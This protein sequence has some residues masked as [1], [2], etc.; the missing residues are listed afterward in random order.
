MKDD[1]TRKRADFHLVLHHEKPGQAA[2]AGKQM[3]ALPHTQ[4]G[5]P[6][7]VD[8]HAI[9]WRACHTNVRRLQCRIVKA[10]KAGRWGKVHALQR[11]L[12]GS[13]SGKALAVKRVSSNSGK[14]TP[15]V[16][17]QLWQ[18]PD[19]KAKAIADL[20]H[21]GYQP[22]PLRRVA[23]PKANGSQRWL[24]IPTLADRAMQALHLLALDPVAETLADP[25]SYGF[26]PCRSTADAMSQCYTALSHQSSAAWVLEGDIKACFD[27][28]SHDWLLAHIRTD[29]SVLRKWLKAGYLKEGRW[30]PTESGTPQGGIIS[31]VLANQTLDGLE[32]E[33]R[34]RFAP[35]RSV[36]SRNKVNLI[37]YADDFIITGS[38]EELLKNEVRPV[39]EKFLK[40]RG[41]ELSKTKT[42]ITHIA[43]GFDFLGQQVRKYGG[44]YL[45]RPST[46][47]PARLLANVRRTLKENPQARVGELIVRLNRIIKGWANYHRHAAS[48]QTFSQV[49]WQIGQMV[50]RWVR[51]R[52]PEKSGAWVR[53][54][55][56]RAQGAQWG[57]LQGEV[58]GRDGKPQKVGLYRAGETAIRRHIKIKGEANPYDLEWE[59]YFEERWARGEVEDQ[60]GRQRMQRLWREQEGR[61]VVCRQRLTRESGWHIHHIQKRV[62]GGSEAMENLVMLHPNCH[63]QVHHQGWR[64]KKPRPVKGASAKA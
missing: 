40:E 12:S 33:L 22:R 26:R 25:N 31:P 17:R 42:R 23:I 30:Y 41:L 62:E 54:K 39:V 34:K 14:L 9:D 63:R 18:T 47:S 15:G 38:S 52:H 60:N 29:K 8:W 7:H 59:I 57:K 13:F 19:K 6:A 50:W 45:T 27:G 32:A 58:T 43:E 51:R 24:G 37:R 2:K 61:C 28:I 11:L 20:Q 16:D 21:R 55:Y 10:V 48:A 4:V 36:K 56:F 46:E 53:K 64:V 49:D 44:K 5:A 35:T 1:L 3:T